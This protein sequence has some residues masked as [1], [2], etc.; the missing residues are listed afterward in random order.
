MVAE[1]QKRAPTFN[2]G[3][4]CRDG[5]SCE[6]WGVRNTRKLQI[7]SFAFFGQAWRAL[8]SI[9]FVIRMQ[10]TLPSV[11]F[12]YKIRPG[13]ALDCDIADVLLYGR[14]RGR[15]RKAVFRCRL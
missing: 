13:R 10:H 12:P 14:A 2:G 6:Y 9:G 4:P 11:G 7:A 15:V 8:R 5:H 1:L 3:D